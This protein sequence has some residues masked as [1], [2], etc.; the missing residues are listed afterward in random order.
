MAK[1]YK[2]TIIVCTIIL[3]VM[4]TISLLLGS[5]I[6]ESSHWAILAQNYSVGIACSSML[7]II[8]TFLQYRAEQYYLKKNIDNGLQKLSLALSIASEESLNINQYRL[9]LEWIEEAHNI[10]CDNYTK[11]SF[12]TPKEDEQ[13]G[14][15]MKPFVLVDLQYAKCCHKSPEYAVPK[16]LSVAKENDFFKFVVDFTTNS[17]SKRISEMFLYANRIDELEKTPRR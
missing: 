8:P 14:L 2:Q 15:K 13:F 16:I 12:W 11:M 6:F 9:C 10:I 17:A 3:F 5:A 1:L 7:V 4:V